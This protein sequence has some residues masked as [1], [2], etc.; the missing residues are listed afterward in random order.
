MIVDVKYG[1]GASDPYKHE[2]FAV[3]TDHG[4][5]DGDFIDPFLVRRD[6]SIIRQLKMGEVLSRTVTQGNLFEDTVKKTYY[7]LV[8]FERSPDG[9]KDTPEVVR[10]CL[11]KID[12]PEDEVIAVEMMGTGLE[13]RMGQADACAIFGGIA[14]SKKKVVL[15]IK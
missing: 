1:K 4:N 2:A 13:G 15:C 7:A 5:G 11:D 9:W 12:I 3:S 8:C 14:R 10:N 6:W